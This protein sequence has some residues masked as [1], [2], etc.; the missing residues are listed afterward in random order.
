MSA[1][2]W[3]SLVTLVVGA[4]VTLHVAYMHRKQMRQIELY[5]QDPS[6]PLTPPPH[7]L[8]VFLKENWF[9]LWC[10]VFGT[11]DMVVLKKDLSSTAPLTRHAVFDIVMDMF[12]V[13]IM[14]LFAILTPIIKRASKLTDR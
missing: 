7:R 6:V 2:A 12:G 8:A 3:I 4:I 9:L 1:S 14:I 10:L 11:F 13:G 5:R